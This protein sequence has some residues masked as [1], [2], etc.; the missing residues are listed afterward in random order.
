M[1]EYRIQ[2]SEFRQNHL[3]SEICILYSVIFAV[4]LFP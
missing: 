3:N 4:P 2:I 1:T